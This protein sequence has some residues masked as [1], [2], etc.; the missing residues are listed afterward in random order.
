MGGN[1][2]RTEK[3]K[4]NMHEYVKEEKNMR[5][6]EGYMHEYCIYMKEKKNEETEEGQKR[7]RKNMNEYTRH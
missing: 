2:T 7:R 1:R 3:G 5:R 6:G 4:E